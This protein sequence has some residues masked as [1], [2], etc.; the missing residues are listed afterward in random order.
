MKKN[1]VIV[2]IFLAC[3]IM[4]AQNKEDIKKITAGYDINK[5]NLLQKQLKLKAV[6][7]KENA[8]QLAKI[9]NW[10]VQI[11][12]AD[13]K[14]EELMKV[15]LD[16][17]PVYYATDNANA[18][19]AS[20]ANQVHT[21]GA[22]GLNLNG[23]GM[24]ARIWDGGR[25]RLTH[26]LFTNRVTTEDDPSSTTFSQHATHVTGTVIASNAVASTKGM[27]YQAT[28]KTYNW[29]SD[30][31]EVLTEVLDGML[32]SNHSYGIPLVSSTNVKQAAWLVGAYIS[33][34]R[35][36]DEIAFLSPY[37]LMVTSAGNSG[38][39]NNTAP[40]TFGFDKLI[41]N[42][43]SK[44]V[45]T[46]ANAQDV[47]VDINGNLTETLQ[48]NNS[49]SQGPADDGRIKP[50]ITGNG[51]GL[52][53][54][55]NGSNTATAT[56]TGTSMSSPSVTGTLLLVQQHYK[57]LNNNFM[58]AATLKGLATH[59]ADD[60]GNVGP[61]ATFGWG[62]INA[63]KCVQTISEN[64]LQSWISE[65][66]LRQNQTY[67]INVKSA[68][69]APLIASI[70]WTD[71]PGEA[72]INT[73]VINSPIPALVNDL[74][75]RISRNSTI[76]FPWRLVGDASLE[77]ERIADNNVDNVENVTLDTPLAGDYTITIKHKGTLVGNSQKFSLIVTGISSTFALNEVTATDLI[78]CGNQNASYG[79]NY[80]QVG[81]GTTNF[82]ATGLPTGAIATFSSNSLN[83]NG[84]VN[85]TLSNLNN[86][87][88]G[89]YTVGIVGNNGVET[90][91]R[92]K[93]LQIYNAT[94]QPITATAPANNIT[95]AATLTTI[96]WIKDDNAES[97]KVDISTTNN[98][99]NIVSAITDIIDN[100]VVTN[101]LDQNT[102]YFYRIIPV[103]R[104]GTGSVSNAVVRSF[105]TGL[106]QCGNVFTATDFSDSTVATTSNGLAIIPIAVS[107]NLKVGDINVALKI[108]HTYVQDMTI[109]LIGPPE[110]GSPEVLLTKETCGEF[111][112]I[113]AIFDDNG[114]LV[115]CSNTPPSISGTITAF[116]QLSN[117]NG[118]LANGIWKIR[119][120]DPHEGDGGTVISASLSICNL[121]QSTLSNNTIDSTVF[122][123][124]PNPTTGIINITLNN[125]TNDSNLVDIFDVQGRSVFKRTFNTS[126]TSLDLSNFQRGIYFVKVSNGNLQKTEKII[127][128]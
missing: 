18:A 106:L 43:V 80:K 37:Y 36:W 9:Y 98:F 57:N 121:T 25:V 51:T 28:A 40:S 30:E 59:T 42:K 61:D 79:F 109:S 85:M 52:L 126:Q 23:Q 4:M 5:I 15:G 56:L 50:D 116:G 29:G 22:M 11:L 122:S 3:N 26:N 44:N 63:K 45:L 35:T 10:P 104:C 110:I 55:S 89:I 33:D 76:F 91:T 64:G 54:A 107:G 27:A 118:A 16:G 21:G 66:T 93:T 111:N 81:S 62:L 123:M 2:L 14:I 88:P 127:L 114:I 6:Q 101:T 105:T 48:I 13:G 58:K 103:N 120:R 41:G 32:L 94:F 71:V 53:S 92:F 113:D 124:Y 75:I 8:V 47:N 90:E 31:S 7:D 100:F 72:N 34:A 73:T 70:T 65:E 97:Y 112:N 1:T 77:A 24:V 119:V 95:D 86:V 83:V 49:S 99:T 115:E 78:I 108:N 12:T 82:T 74:D 46:V 17:K 38:M 96:K 84:I 68:G 69:N 60:A 39:D 128:Q 19:K 102:R 117:F 20:R 87:Q 125:S 67:T